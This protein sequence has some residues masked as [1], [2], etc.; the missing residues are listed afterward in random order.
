MY[1]AHYLR[2]LAKSYPTIQAASAE[3]VNLKAILSLPKG[4]EYFFSDLHGEHQAF[5][6]MLKSASGMIRNKIDDLFQTSVS[7]AERNALAMLIYEPEEEMARLYP[8]TKNWEEWCKITIYRLVEVFKLISTKY[9]RSKVRKRMP[10]DYQ[11]IID[12]LMYYDND[13]NRAHYYHSIVEAIVESRT[14]C[15][16]ICSLC[17]SI[18]ELAIDKLHIIGDIYDRGPH[19]DLIMNELMRA[20]DVDIQ[21]GNHDISWIGA[22]CGN[23][24]CI[25]NVIRLGISYNN[26][27]LLEDGYGINLRA[28]S[29]FASETY[30]Q[31]PCDI[32]MPH[33]L[34]QNKYD[35]VDVKLAAKMH[36]A[37]A[38]IQFKVEG[39]LIHQHPEY[40]MEDRLLLEKID[41]KAGT[42]RINQTEYPLTDHL[43]P[44]VDPDHPLQLT[45]EEE[46]L[47]RTIAASF[48]HSELLRTHIRFLLSHGSMYRC[49]NGNLL[50]H[51]CIPLTEEG[52]L[53]TVWLDGK[54]YRGRSYLDRIDEIVRQ[55]YFAPGGSEEK[56]KAR[57]FLWF[58]WCA[59]KSPLFGKSKMAAFESYFLADRSLSKEEMNPYYALVEREDICEMLLREF[60]LD[61]QSSHIINGH[62]PVKIKQGE[63]PVKGGGRLFFIDGGMSKAYQNKTG[64]AGYTFIFNSRFMALAEHR[65]YHK[66]AGE[67][68]RMENSP[69]VQ[70]VEAMKQRV[71]V[72]DTDTGKE[73]SSQVE[74]LKALIAAYR[75]GLIKEA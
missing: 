33:I 65:P 75:S 14:E 68:D 44:T 1:D 11:Y 7:E 55:A 73:L 17:D 53:D 61:P 74:E 34:D 57:D 9:T 59:P 49:T 27:D 23:W 63:S 47:M 12:E 20:H 51:G 64:I 39:Q 46:N 58:L 28:L 3:M 16:F 36:K 42:I 72:A 60:G 6:Y 62:V 40:G 70:V 56:H 25:A 8:N 48:R 35:P 19:A 41:F 38:V 22:V 66:A 5:I 2:L 52:E 29:V 30:A 50:Y 31:D 21:W 45:K 15:R 54:A 43:F 37:I 13:D 18:R 24:A 71:R 4:T 32:F 67:T 26:F 69:T 10:R